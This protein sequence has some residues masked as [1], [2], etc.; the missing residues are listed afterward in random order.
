MKTAFFFENFPTQSWERK[1]NDPWLCNPQII[2]QLF[3]PQH[4]KNV[5]VH[6]NSQTLSSEC[7][8]L[9]KCGA[10]IQAL[11]SKKVAMSTASR[12]GSTCFLSFSLSKSQ[13]TPCWVSLE[14]LCVWET[15]LLHLPQLLE[16]DSQPN[17]SEIPVFQGPQG[18]RW[19]RCPTLSR[20][21]E[22]FHL[23]PWP[24]E[25]LASPAALLWRRQLSRSPCL[26]AWAAVPSL[27]LVGLLLLAS[28]PALLPALL[29]LLWLFGFSRSLCYF[30]TVV[31]RL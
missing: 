8:D 16:Q 5:W 17:C 19:H 14:D 18:T 7:L 30:H 11:S 29:S 28:C 10:S 24:V 12:V 23:P 31:L 1:A 21:I 2:L 22:T 26:H 9:I 20:I 6:S 3:E 4:H 27:F 25:S 13:K 15:P